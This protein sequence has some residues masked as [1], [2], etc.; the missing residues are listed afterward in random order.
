MTAVLSM[1][2]AAESFSQDARSHYTQR[3][4]QLS[5]LGSELTRRDRRVGHLRVALFLVAVPLLL[6][7]YFVAPVALPWIVPGWMSFFGFL[8]AAAYQERVGEQATLV[9][10]RQHFNRRA[11]ARLARDWGSL[12]GT[13][14]ADAP[15]QSAVAEDLDL[16]GPASLFALVSLSYTAPGREALASWISAPADSSVLRQRQQLAQQWADRTEER[17]TFLCLARQVALGASPPEEFV[18]WASGATLSQR[19]RLIG[20]WVRWLPLMW[21]VPVV[22]L[23]T[24]TLALNAALVVALAILVGNLLISM[25]LGGAVH[26]EFTAAAGRGANAREY[27]QLFRLAAQM[28]AEGELAG[29]FREVCASRAQPGITSLVG[30]LRFALIRHHPLLFVVLYL[31][32][33]LFLLWDF[34]ILPFLERWQRRHGGDVRSWFTTLG[35]VEA[36]LSLAALRYDYPDWAQPQFIEPA[37]TA[38]WSGQGVGHPLLPDGGR[39]TNDVE[40]GPSGRVLLVT[41]SNMSGKSTLL[42]TI[43]LNTVLA[44]M[45]AVVCARQLRLP[46]LRLATSIRIRDSLHQ[47]VSLY[48]AELIRLK[49]IVEQVQR[50][51]SRQWQVLYLLDE[52]LQGT[53]SRERQIAVVH[54]VRSL[55]HSSAI[56]AMSTHD[57][58]LA[59][60]PEIAAVADVVHFRESFELDAEGREQMR[61][62]YRLRSGVAPTTN[63]L[64]LLEI[65]GL[66]DAAK[67]IRGEES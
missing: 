11:G 58:D 42:R 26:S 50:S 45:G 21:L 31:P 12:A 60:D 28:P 44:Q 20:G 64:K 23:L 40:L 25:F 57:L 52:I 7:G 3:L 4:Q 10:S 66:A 17:E 59:T 63:A 46:P 24:G 16:F 1:H 41:G 38:T 19:H 13:A 35:E 34:H 36:M 30:V 48:M 5:E 14:P 37:P 29:R 61:F 27:L 32:L 15:L 39:V 6:I 43:G 47:G 51:D 49:E 22:G 2:D 54:V 53:N 65:V 56:G 9:R 8:A 33:Q 55:L 62:D 18:R 67:R